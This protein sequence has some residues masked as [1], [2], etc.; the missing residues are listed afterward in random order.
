MT[1]E[2][3]KPRKGW[4]FFYLAGIGWFVLSALAFWAYYSGSAP[5]DTLGI[6]VSQLVL[7]VIFT[8]IGWRQARTKR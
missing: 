5:F 7:G 6:P 8:W 4:N 2:E 3:P 1:G